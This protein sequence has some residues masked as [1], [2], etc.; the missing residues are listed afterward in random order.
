[1]TPSEQIGTELEQ[2][3][4]QEKQTLVLIGLGKLSRLELSKQNNKGDEMA[5]INIIKITADGEQTSIEGDFTPEKDQTAV[6]H[7]SGQKETI[8][9]RPMLEQLMPYYQLCDD[10][11]FE[12]NL[13]ILA[14]NELVRRLSPDAQMAIHNVMEVLMGQAPK[15]DIAKIVK[16]GQERRQVELAELSEKGKS[17]KVEKLH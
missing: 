11:L 8:K 6:M 4:S 7:P 15:S 9:G 3:V 14:S 16:E 1:M 2:T 10:R 13:R 12:M 5:K 17:K